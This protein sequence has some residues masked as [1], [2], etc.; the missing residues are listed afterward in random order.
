[1]AEEAGQAF[2]AAAAHQGVAQSL[3]RLW[4]LPGA[5][6]HA[7]AAIRT[8]RELGA[9]WELASVLGDRGAILRVA[10]RLDEAERDLREAFALCR[11]LSERT[12]VTWTA[13]E[14][15]RTLAMT[16]DITAARDVL[17]DPVSRTAEGEPG[18]TVSLLVAEA[19]LADRAGDI[20]FAR[21]K[22][23]AALEQE[24]AAAIA[25]PHAAMIWWVG[26]LYGAEFV[27]GP[28]VL[29]ESRELL[30]RNGWEQALREPD[31]LRSGG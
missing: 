7:D 24:S 2:T 4:R 9:R 26:R 17:D 30:A 18:S 12:L 22:S 29:E 11:D 28:F 31:L 3:R 5:E 21:A 25:N 13:S 16:G 14:L 6:E 1:V 27:G 10:G 8:L 19:V 15:A 20:E 23:L